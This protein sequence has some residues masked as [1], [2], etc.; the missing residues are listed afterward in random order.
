MILYFL[1][2]ISKQMIILRQQE[3]DYSKVGEWM[4]KRAIR[5]GRHDIAEAGINAWRKTKDPK[6]K[7]EILKVVKDAKE[8]M[9]EKK[10]AGMTGS[11][12]VWARNKNGQV[13]SKLER[14]GN[15]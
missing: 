12:A 2:L 4:A 8:T 13:T 6:T 14:L 15:K 5:H 7:E 10:N 3:K 1:F 11:T 9:R